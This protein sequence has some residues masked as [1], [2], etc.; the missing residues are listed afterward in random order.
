MFFYLVKDNSGWMSDLVFKS[1]DQAITSQSWRV[2]DSRFNV[3][4]DFPLTIF[5]IDTELGLMDEV[6]VVREAEMIAR[7]Q[8]KDSEKKGGSK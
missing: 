1:I 2:E 8:K 4:E 6:K 3:S 5:Q 7:F